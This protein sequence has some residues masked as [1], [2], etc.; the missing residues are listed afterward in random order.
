MEELDREWEAWLGDAERAIEASLNRIVEAYQYIQKYREFAECEPLTLD[1]SP[2]SREEWTI[3]V[4]GGDGE[5]G[6]LEQPR[7]SVGGSWDHHYYYES[8][9]DKA[10][11]ELKKNPRRRYLLNELVCYGF[12][13]YLAKRGRSFALLLAFLNEYAPDRINALL[14]AL[15]GFAAEI[16][17][18]G[19][20][21]RKRAE[22]A[23]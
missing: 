23:K 19:E 21:A 3:E 22:Q 14:Q 8:L 4:F 17:K 10:R 12:N 18:R 5:C 15:D 16:Q 9:C 6:Y 20:E 13:R 7:F 1:I 2:F 11:S